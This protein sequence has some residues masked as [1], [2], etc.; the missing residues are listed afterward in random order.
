[1]VTQILEIMVIQLTLYLLQAA[2]SFLD[3]T[4]FT[5]YK[6]VALN[7]N[8]LNGLFFGP[9]FYFL[10]L[11]YTGAATAY[12]TL[13]CMVVAVSR[14]ASGDDQKLKILALA[15]GGLQFLTIW[16]LGYSRDLRS[17]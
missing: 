12:F 16:W 6:Y 15:C 5:G 8:M 1:M 13:K 4:A 7:I 3:L 10:S 11:L 9:T 17:T 14:G 2:N